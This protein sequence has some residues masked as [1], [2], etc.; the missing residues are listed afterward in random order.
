MND[1]LLLNIIL[2]QIKTSK[3]IENLR[4]Q[5]E[6]LTRDFMK[7]DYI[8]NKIIEILSISKNI[9]YDKYYKGS[10]EDFEKFLVNNLN[11]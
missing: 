10:R 7:L 6:K 9:Y 5:E 1:D 3:E 2:N 11:K 8:N 4:N